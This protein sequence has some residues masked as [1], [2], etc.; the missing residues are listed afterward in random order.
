MKEAALMKKIRLSMMPKKDGVETGIG[1]TPKRN[2]LG[3]AETKMAVP[4]VT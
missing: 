3:Y 4:C 2:Y 1:I